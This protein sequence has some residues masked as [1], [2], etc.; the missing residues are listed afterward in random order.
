MKR[1]YVIQIYAGYEDLVKTDL[2]RR[3]AQKGMQDLFGQVLIPSAKVKNYLSAAEEDQQLF[4]GYMLIEMDLMPETMRLVVDS[5][6]VLRFLGGN[7]PMPL[8]DQE[9]KRVVS[10]VKGEVALATKKTEFVVGREVQVTEGPFAG[11]VGIIDS[12]DLQAEKLS[13]LVSI[14][15]RLTP[16]ELRFD[17]VKQ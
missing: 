4:P 13:V 15:G 6:R 5:P 1:W 7:Q 14:L 11:F 9:I 3:I 16:V 2:E 8:S 17:Q 10:Q 12:I